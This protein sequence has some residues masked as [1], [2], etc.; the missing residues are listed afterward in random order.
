[1]IWY[2]VFVAGA[3]AAI[4]VH[5]RVA[6]LGLGVAALGI[7]QFLVAALADCLETGRHLF[8]FH[9]CTDLTICFAVAGLVFG[10]LKTPC[11]KSSSSRSS[12]P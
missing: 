5:P 1:M 8:I 2:A 4:R 11:E 9:V 3:I 7:G 6:W 12:V 10:S